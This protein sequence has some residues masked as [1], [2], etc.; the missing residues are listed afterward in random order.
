[1]SFAPTLQMSETSLKLGSARIVR[2]RPARVI[3]KDDIAKLKRYTT[4]I[5]SS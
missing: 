3:S 4:Y 2:R 5:L 1:M